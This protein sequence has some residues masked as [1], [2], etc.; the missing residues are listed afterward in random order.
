MAPRGPP[1]ALD[2][3]FY[4]EV[5]VQKYQ[6]GCSVPQITAWLKSEGNEVR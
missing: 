3:E 4:Y 5:L 1:A 6:G 2:W